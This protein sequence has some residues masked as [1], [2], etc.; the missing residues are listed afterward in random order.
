MALLLC[1]AGPAHAEAQTTGQEHWVETGAIRIRIWEKFAGSPDAKPVIVLAHGSATAGQES[2]D[3]QVPGKPAY[4]LM[5][6]LA[7]D[8]FDVF[9]P[10][11]R[12]F[13]RST[14]PEG[15][16][17]T[18]EA[19]EDLGAAID[20]VLKLR[21]VANVGLLA[22]S[23]G[24]QYAGLFVMAH[25]EK[26]SR[27]AAYAQMHAASPDIVKRRARLETFRQSPY[28]TI[29]EAG[30]KT[31]FTSMTPP[32][33]SEP[34]VVDAFA[35]AAASVETRTPTG[36]QIDMVTLPPMVS[37][38]RI[39]VPTLIIHGQYDDVAD[40]A[41]LMP[42]FAGLANP[43]KVYAVIPDAG[44]MAHLQKGHRI[45]QKHVSGFFAAGR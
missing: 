28:M 39:T 24:T 21:G 44:H 42:F 15:G 14:H 36:P 20:A 34:D 4:S 25:P 26:V 35:R 10:D 17:S 18:A 43:E 30:W 5:D 45:F 33:V 8:G 12:G 31:R 41:G 2:F 7:N 6:V 3:L 40:V 11:M 9:A 32:D 1:A 27:Y 23:W 38:P 37:A 22:W 19:S 16:V 13:G 29:P